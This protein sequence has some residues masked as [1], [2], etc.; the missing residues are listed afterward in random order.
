MSPTARSPG[1]SGRAGTA[2]RPPGSSARQASGSRTW[3]RCSPTTTCRRSSSPRRP[4]TPSRQRSSPR[5]LGASSRSPGSGRSAST[6]PRRRRGSPARSS[7]ARPTIPERPELLLR[8]ADAAFQAGRPREA[9]AALDEAL[10]LFRAR[11]ENEAEA[12]ALILLARVAHVLGEGRQVALASRGGGASRAGA[13]RP[14]TRRCLHAA[15]H[16]ALPRGLI[17]RGDRRRRPCAARSPRRSACPSRPGRSAA[18]GNARAY[19]G[20]PDGLA[21]MERAL[22]MLI[23]QGAGSRSRHSPEQ[24]RHRPLPAPGARPLARRL[25]AGDRLLRAA[26]PNQPGGD[27]GGRLPGP[28]RRARPP[29]GGARASRCARCCRRGERRNMGAYVGA[30]ARAGDPP[31]SRRGGGRVRHR[32]LARRG[33]AHA[34]HVRRNRRGARGRRRRPARRRRTGPGARAPRRDRADAR[35]T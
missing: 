5:R 19:L 18:R 23:E 28:A 30:R 3:R 13:A 24:P 10:D 33:C 16:G 32:R 27:D 8:W 9:A 22:P 1:R 17:R 25:R 15:R 11:G 31:R 26:R 4:A 35:R 2:P 20:D 14:D 34:R 29:G 12:R 6:P 7:S 21:E